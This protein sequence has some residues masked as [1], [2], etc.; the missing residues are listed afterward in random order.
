MGTDEVLD[1][2]RR[3]REFLLRGGA[4]LGAIAISSSAVELGLN[5]ENWTGRAFAADESK[6]REK[7]PAF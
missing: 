6:P 7:L 1:T 5:A 3:R 2:R 4:G